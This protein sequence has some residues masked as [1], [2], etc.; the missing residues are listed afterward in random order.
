[1]RWPGQALR[2]GVSRA[3]IALVRTS[4]WGGAHETLA[5]TRLDDSAG[6]DAIGPALHGLMAEVA[7]AGWP[8]SVVLADDLVRLWQVAP[9][10]GCTRMGDLEAAAALRFQSLFGGTAAGWRIAA[11]WDPLRPFLAAAMPHALLATLEQ[12]ARDRRCHLVEAVPQFVAA[13]N[14]WRRVRR[15]D[16]WFGMYHG[17]VLTLAVSRQGA[18]EGIRATLAP[19]DA[20]R[21]WL[22]AHVT[23]EALRL[24]VEP[25]QRLQLCG[26][27]PSRWNGA[28][29]DIACS[30]LGGAVAGLS[31]LEQ[32]ALTGAMR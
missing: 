2:L 4:R 16:A 32:L 31:E 6:V 5:L 17:A 3:G 30:M 8:L 14:Q 19:P 11:D 28:A 7:C 9:P 18:L 20:G 12:A 22:D 26:S 1:R 10:P 24:G 21:D 23:R 25:P 15:A 29:G 13:L 27:V